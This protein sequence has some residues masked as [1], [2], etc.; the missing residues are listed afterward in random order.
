[1]STIPFLSC[2]YEDPSTKHDCMSSSC[3]LYMLFF[4]HI[5][6]C[7]SLQASRCMMLG[8]IQA[9]EDGLRAKAY[10]TR[11]ALRPRLRSPIQGAIAKE[12]RQN[13]SRTAP[14]RRGNSTCFRHV[15]THKSTTD[16]KLKM[17]CWGSTS[18][19]NEKEFFMTGNRASEP[20][21]YKNYTVGTC[22]WNP[23]GILWNPFKS[24][25]IL[26]NPME[27]YQIPWNPIKSQI[28]SHFFC[29]TFFQ[30]VPPT[31]HDD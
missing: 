27:S 17:G 20:K 11:T 30:K 14:K 8:K 31:K 13:E 24:Y 9:A 22:H 16:L 12:L 18:D 6:H 10:V 26:W 5:Q 19:M 2:G 23:M 28:P 21:G 29:R 15:L 3:I 25:G 1:M 4:P 7:T